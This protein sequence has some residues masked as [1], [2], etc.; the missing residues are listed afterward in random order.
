MQKIPVG[1]LGAT[2]VVGQNFARLLQSHPWFEL[3]AAT[4]SEHS[5]GKPYG[6]LILTDHSAKLPCRIL[7]SALDHPIAK[8]V[9]ANYAGQGYIIVSNAK[10]HR[11]EP[12]VP[13]MIPEVNAEHLNLLQ[14]QE[15][16]GKII[17]VPNCSATGLSLALK[18][19]VD[20]GLEAV[21]VVTMQAVSGAGRAAKT[22]DIE[23]NIIPFIQDEEEKIETETKKILSL[24]NL[25]IS[26]QCNRVPVSDGH[27]AC[28]SIQ[29]KKKPKA[30]E[31]IAAWR[32]FKSPF[33]HLPSGLEFPLC[34]F[35]QI[36][37]PQ[38]KKHRL[39]GNGMAVSLGRLRP[40]ALFDYKFTLLSHNAIRGAAGGALLTAEL[41]VELLPI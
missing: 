37:F 29:F 10:S 35:D 30:E 8:E 14:N 39:L 6:H 20:L 2:G 22:L 18:P 31:I 15:T 40:C 16:P 23:D 41:F 11:M 28:V 26:A 32:R 33:A 4:A 9:E 17:T 24:P 21:H 27:T 25:T 34:Y 12:H 36:D 19:L 7:F 13:L 3:T 38:P 5:F 1:I